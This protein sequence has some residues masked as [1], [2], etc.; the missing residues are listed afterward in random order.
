MPGY[1]MVDFSLFVYGTCARLTHS[2]FNKPADRW[3]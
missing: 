3:T 1:R 2:F